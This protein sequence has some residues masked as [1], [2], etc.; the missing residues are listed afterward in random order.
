MNLFILKLRKSFIA[1]TLLFS[2]LVL[3]SASRDW[4]NPTIDVATVATDNSYIEVTFSEGVFNSTGAALSNTI[5]TEFN[6]NYSDGGSGVAVTVSSIKQSD[7]STDPAGGETVLR[8]L[9]NVTGTP[10][11]AET[12][13]IVPVDGNSVF[14]TGGTNPMAGTQ[15]TGV[16]NME[17]EAEP[18]VTGLNFVNNTTLVVS[19]N[20][21]VDQTTAEAIGNYSLD[22]GITVSGAV[23]SGS[24]VTLTVSDMSA[25]SEGTDI[26]VTVI[27]VTDLNSNV[28]D[29]A[30]DQA[31]T[32]V[33][34]VVPGFSNLNV[35]GNNASATV[36]FTENVWATVN[37]TGNI[38]ETNLE[39]TISS[40]TATLQS[41]TISHTGGSN[42]ATINL[43]LNG[44]P[45][46]NEI[47]TVSPFSNSD[48]FDGNG[49]NIPDAADI[50]ANLNDETDPGF[51][52]LTVNAANTQATLTF[53]EVVW[54]NNDMTGDLVDADFDVSITG[55]T[56]TLTSSTITHTGGTNSLTID[57]TLSGVADGSEVLTVSPSANNRVFDDAGLDVPDADEITQNLNDLTLPSINSVVVATDNLSALITFSESVSGSNSS[58]TSIVEAD[59]NV[60]ITGGSATL[61]SFTVSHTAGTDNATINLTLNNTPA[62]GSELLTVGPADGASIFD[63]ASPTGN[64][65]DA[66]Q[67]ANDN[68]DDRKPATILS[69]TLDTEN[70]FIDVFFSD[71]VYSSGGSGAL[72]PGAF[73]VNFLQN[74]GAASD[75]TISSVTKTDG[76][77]A[78]GG[79]TELRLNLSITD[80]PPSGVESI[81]IKPASATSIFDDDSVTPN[82]MADTQSGGVKVLNDKL[83]P[84]V[85]PFE[86]VLYDAVGTDSDTIR[87][88]ISEDL[89]IADGNPLTGFTLSQAATGSSWNATTRQGRF[90]APA[91]TWNLSSTISY[92]SGGVGNIIDLNNNEMASFGATTLAAPGQVNLSPGDIV[93]TSF[94]SIVDLGGDDDFVQFL[95]LKDVEDGTKINFT[96]RGWSGT[97]FTTN[98]EQ[99]VVWTA[100]GF[101]YAGTEIT[102]TD[103][104]IDQGG[105]DQVLA[106]QGEVS[107]PTFLAGI[108][109]NGSWQGS[110]SEPSS[111]ESQSEVPTGLTDG[112]FSAIASSKNAGAYNIPTETN[113]GTVSSLRG[114]ISSISNW[115]DDDNAG[116]V[117][118]RSDGINFDLPPDVDSY[119]PTDGDIVNPTLAATSS[120]ITI[121]W[122]ADIQ[123]G[124][125]GNIVLKENGTP[126]HTFTAGGANTTI[127]GTNLTLDLAGVTSLLPL[128]HGSTYT[129]EIQSN[130]VTDVTDGNLNYPTIE[131]YDLV[132]DGVAASI[133]TATAET[134]L[135]TYEAYVAVTFDEGVW[136]DAATSTPITETDF[137]VTAFNDNGGRITGVTVSDVKLTNDLNPVGGES[138]FKLI[139]DLTPD[140]ASGIEDFVVSVVASSVYD[141]AGNATP[142]TENTGSLILKD[143]YPPEIQTTPTPVVIATG[144]TTF[145]IDVTFD[146]GIWGNAGNS[147]PVTASDFDRVFVAGP[148]TA[149][150]IS[151]VKAP[152]NSVEGSASALVG[153]ETT[154]RVFLTGADGPPDGT[155]TIE[156]LAVNGAIFDDAGNST[157]GTESTGALTVEDTVKPDFFS[158]DVDLDNRWIDV[159]F[160]EGIF[161]NDGPDPSPPTGG[162]T[163]TDFTL[164]FAQNTGT[165]T[166]ATLISVK[167][168]DNADSTL[169][170]SASG[171]ESTFRFYI[172]VTG[173]PNGLETVTITP[174][175]GLADKFWDFSNNGNDVTATSGPIN[176]QDNVPPAQHTVSWTVLET[177]INGA[178]QNSVSFEITGAEDQST[179]DWVITDTTTPT[180]LEITGTGTISGSSA[181]I[182]G[183]DVG[184]AGLI[185]GNITVSVILT[186]N[187]PN[188]NPNTAETDIIVKDA[189]A[190]SSPTISDV[191]SNGGTVVVNRWNSTNTELLVTVPIANDAS[192]QN[193][194]I[195]ILA[196]VGGGFAS[197]FGPVN[198]PT[199]NTDQ[200][201]P[202][203]AAT[204][205]GFDSGLIDG[206]NVSF[207]IIMRDAF[208]NSTQSPT[209]ADFMLIDQTSAGA[210]TVG[211]V[212]ASGGNVVAGYWNSTNGNINIDVPIANDQTLD[213]GSIQIQ[214][215]AGAE[216]LENLGAPVTIGGVN[217]T[218]TVTID[219]ATFEA[220]SAGLLE[221]EVITFTAILFDYGGN[222][223]TLGTE[224]TTTII[225]DQTAP[226]QLTT[227]LA[228]ARGGNEFLNYYNS[229]NTSFE[230]T[231]PIDSD[232]TLDGG[233]I[234]LRANVNSGG[235]EDLGSPFSIVTIDVG[236]NKVVSV[237]DADFESL[238][239]GLVS[240]NAYSI[241]ITATVTDASGNSTQFSQSTNVI[242]FDEVEPLV[243]SIVRDPSFSN[244]T[245]EISVRLDVTFSEDV[246]SVDVGDFTLYNVGISPDP[247]ISLVTG[248]GTAYEV[249]VDGLENRE[250]DVGV[251][252]VQGNSPTI[253]DLA[254]NPYTDDFDLADGAEFF[255]VDNTPPGALTFVA[256]D[257]NVAFPVAGDLSITFTEDVQIVVPADIR[258]RYTS[259][260]TDI[261]FS[262]NVVGDQLII[263]PTS[264]L[265]DSTGVY[266]EVLNGAI[267]DIAGNIYIGVNDKNGWNFRTYGPPKITS[268]SP[269]ACI[270]TPITIIGQN[271][272]SY[273]GTDP[274]QSAVTNVEFCDPLGGNCVS[275]TS[276]ITIV[277]DSELTVVVPN[278][279]PSGQIRLTKAQQNIVSLGTNSQTSTIS[280][281]SIQTETGP[282]FADL[283]ATGPFSGG[284][285]YDA[286]VC[287]NGTVITADAQVTI[288]GGIT[289]QN[290][291]NDYLIVYDDDDGG[292]APDPDVPFYDN[293]TTFQI[294]PPFNGDNIIKLV[295]VRDNYTSCFVPS[296]NIRTEGTLGGQVDIKEWIRTTLDA[297]GIDNDG[298]TL[299]EIE[300]LLSDNTTYPNGDIDLSDP[301][302]M[303]VV[304]SV[305]GDETGVSWDVS[306]GPS[307]GGGSFQTSSTILQ[308]TY[309]VS[310]SD[311][312]FPQQFRV[313]ITSDDPADPNPCETVNDELEIIFIS[314]PKANPG[315]NQ[316][317]CLNDNLAP[318]SAILTGGADGVVWSRNAGSAASTFDG[319]WG[320][321]TDGGTTYLETYTQQDGVD[322]DPEYKP[323]PQEETAGTALI[324]ADP[325][326]F[327]NVPQ[328]N[329]STLTL[330]VVANPVT[331]FVPDVDLCLGDEN[332]LFSVNTATKQSTY[333]WTLGSNLELVA[334]GSSNAILVNILK[335]EL[336]FDYSN[337]ANGP[338]QLG[339]EVIFTDIESEQVGRA[340][341][342]DITDNGSTGTIRVRMITETDPDPADE[343]VLT[344]SNSGASANISSDI[345]VIDPEPAQ[346]FAETSITV[347]ETSDLDG[348][349][350]TPSVINIDMYD[351]PFA[352]FNPRR[353]HSIT[354]EVPYPLELTDASG[355]AYAT[356][357]EGQTPYISFS[358]SGVLKIRQSGEDN[359]FFNSSEMT[360][361]DLGKHKVN[362][363][364]VFNYG[365]SGLGCSN[366]GTKTFTVN[367]ATNNIIG[368]NL[369]YCENDIIT[370]ALE[371]QLLQGEEFV[372]MYIKIGN[373]EIPP[374]PY[375]QGNTPDQYTGSGYGLLFDPGLLPADASDDEYFFDP[376]VAALNFTPGKNNQ[377]EVIAV[378]VEFEFKKVD[379]T[380]DVLNQD[381]SIFEQPEIEFNFDGSDNQGFVVTPSEE[382]ITCDYDKSPWDSD[383]ILLRPTN[384]ASSNPNTEFRFTYEVRYPEKNPDLRG[385]VPDTAFTVL[386]DEE[387]IAIYFND[388]DASDPRWEFDPTLIDTSNPDSVALDEYV[389]V[390]VTYRY[391]LGLP[392]GSELTSLCE[393][394]VS[395]VIRVYPEPPKPE[396]REIISQMIVSQVCVSD[397]QIGIEI[398]SLA[399]G[400]TISAVVNWWDAKDLVGTDQTTET[401]TQFNPEIAA[402]SFGKNN[403]WMRQ[404]FV[405]CHSDTLEF[406]YEKLEPFDF[407]IATQCLNGDPVLVNGDPPSN[408]VQNSGYP[409]W[410]V[411]DVA[412]ASDITQTASTDT[413]TLIVN[414]GGL[415][416]VTYNVITENQCPAE[417]TKRLV[418]GDIVEVDGDE[419]E[420]FDDDDG[421]WTSVFLESTGELVPNIIWDYGTLSNAG[422]TLQGL[423]ADRGNVWG[424]R[425]EKQGINKPL[426]YRTTESDVDEYSYLYSACYDFSNLDRP[427][428]AFDLLTKTL[429]GSDDGL[430]LQYSTDMVFSDETT[431]TTVVSTINGQLSGLNWYNATGLGPL[432]LPGLDN[433]FGYGWNDGS[434]NQAPVWQEAKHELSATKGDTVIFRFIA[435]TERFAGS[436]SENDPAGF[437]IDNF[438]VGNRTRTVLLENF[439]NDSQVA[440][441]LADV[442]EEN[443]SIRNFI[444]RKNGTSENPIF[445]NPEVVVI[446]YRTGFPNPLDDIYL[447]NP[448]EVGAR[449]QYYGISNVPQSLL[450]GGVTYDGVN[451]A[452]G[453]WNSFGE[454]AYGK[455]TLRLSEIEIDA[456]IEINS[457]GEL[458][459]LPRIIPNRDID[460]DAVLH[461]AVVEKG[462]TPEE[463]QIENFNT[464][465]DSVSY[466]FKKMLPSP[467]GYRFNGDLDEGTLYQPPTGFKWAISNFYGPGGPTPGDPTSIEDMSVIIFVQDDTEGAE[468]QIFQSATF[469][470]T[471]FNVITGLDQEVQ[472]KLISLYPNPADKQTRLVM[473]YRA[474]EDLTV[475]LYDNFGK[476]VYRGRI[477]KG[478]FT[479]DIN[480]TKLS[481]G[482]YQVIIEG[483]DGA[484]GMKRLIVTH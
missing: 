359:Y 159:T 134:D 188:G 110:M 370:S 351:R 320:F 212:I 20:E 108:M 131:N 207:R 464:N 38:D 197:E 57:L 298:N 124:T 191:S 423:V 93:F 481:I 368:L 222:P 393:S 275:Q 177:Y 77:T 484:V 30:N 249:T 128:T 137:S 263:D 403:Y 284:D 105:G 366:T 80:G 438:F 381:L 216:P 247:T 62:D 233:S 72:G 279:A 420:S 133:Q 373:T 454:I 37:R 4:A 83:A 274:L 326:A 292:P 466:V 376:R 162:V 31:T 59:L 47:L 228:Q 16:L 246:I 179:Y 41:Y 302:I 325:T 129:L 206:D 304:P 25:L 416:D 91:G 32:S 346:D 399:A 178:N 15:T 43:T 422:G 452:R 301:V 397:E 85:T 142:D 167:L 243:N 147:Q 79:E 95:L 365:I 293:G 117:P 217:T 433:Q 482:M 158:A 198:I 303:N 155:E 355:I 241:E 106:Y 64:A 421:G 180:P 54:A 144:A 331:N 103:F 270:Q 470:V 181:T 406:F 12:V 333:Q 434:E 413:A 223:G 190:P 450:D 11:G 425:L 345:T 200:I 329:P 330:E 344:G 468:K 362:W 160:A 29:N 253:T 299:G 148:L 44:V 61:S 291:M 60:Q 389:E 428:V 14:D 369:E 154:V 277:S 255:V 252:L 469:D 391:T 256:G 199:V 3:T 324:D 435:G 475:R 168:P 2:L 347:V 337:E 90:T 372:R 34:N 116:N 257:N 184:A 143:T 213:Q 115:D 49:T 82:P 98:A 218:Q 24:D 342:T 449:A 327:G 23:K 203:P 339:E 350:A 451:I 119:S 457:E 136:G 356:G 458:V 412:L 404:E 125:T 46:G 444:I 418:F 18:T 201:I 280:G 219:A 476:E 6:L 36:T 186:D 194:S 308:P 467:S 229:T 58:A 121:T 156:I 340:E 75:I 130:S 151:S 259:D 461:I 112:S 248:S 173:T 250:G 73:S 405:Y 318:L 267:T 9:L 97:Q 66:G 382:F 107:S 102:I 265:P 169:A 311:V 146:E 221:G 271:F 388:A 471:P 289:A 28:V 114:A 400:N 357:I 210:F 140:L 446:N 309:R 463:L 26:T 442:K 447:D 429:T 126:V 251:H 141:E 27:N 96:R 232:P 35:A 305:A 440:S 209:A 22:N 352:R 419:F 170:T 104:E 67:S 328:N 282:S 53:T 113:T 439:T 313:R 314:D 462:V 424:T 398:D 175:D 473:P 172:D 273:P 316:V 297:G 174:R 152:D 287:N 427:M 139:L 261:P 380:L 164:T 431:W 307:S 455:R 48:A 165:A 135:P 354:D 225:I 50:T 394:V 483:K 396:I 239:G 185:D 411:F 69:S 407:E 237:S 76:N 111:N 123:A 17:D 334:G 163:A 335:A 100:S 383:P 132:V 290:G 87:F 459:V 5:G 430:I 153:G 99:T 264:N 322:P 478:E 176:L 92:T 45:D 378:K 161:T 227:D 8:F 474:R 456:D 214:A 445:S 402:L 341:I 7:G 193:G 245:K 364:R 236:T 286:N 437:L 472:N 349:V 312:A 479:L 138:S 387:Q 78:T 281:V 276:N 300:V 13:E 321:T 56:A 94:N 238:D 319:T 122:N 127:L 205:E 224:S 120:E 392:L 51:Q 150:N 109:I 384:I 317:L 88:F 204:F 187:S 367:A 52:S 295:S 1:V 408:A 332:V 272:A 196:D 226:T 374:E 315:S 266:V 278:N 183:I 70:A 385:A 240:T 192:L 195:E 220:M 338:F 118:F 375:V 441:L 260:D 288:T 453:V 258:L 157:V 63:L 202:I 86:F 81:E 390:R 361:D 401:G 182:S 443:D 395:K 285:G 230:V 68:L 84:F 71:G 74:G 89:Q 336:E 268:V 348:C 10:T 234:Q 145:Y 269:I 343:I 480:S 101:T 231:V 371:P 415:Y 21:E 465:E 417:I 360:E 414:Q 410:N 242:A 42:T 283:V 166:A 262:A 323:S 432:S 296:G 244:P 33:D 377:D 358:G 477:A 379:E 211:N 171:G 436:Q 235:F 254:G 189:T 40:G 310:L 386:S 353:S 208:D 460:G 215:R 65:M 149:L 363:R 409:N 39:V 448:A 55:G 306:N 294:D 426:W 19:F